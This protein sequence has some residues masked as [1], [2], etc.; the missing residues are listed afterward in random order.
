MRDEAQEQSR[1]EVEG[2][3]QQTRPETEESLHQSRPEAEGS[4]HPHQ[5]T[6][7]Q[8]DPNIPDY[9]FSEEVVEDRFCDDYTTGTDPDAG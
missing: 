1:P 4:S 8:W 5:E 9:I 7:P 3:L 6:H 2:S